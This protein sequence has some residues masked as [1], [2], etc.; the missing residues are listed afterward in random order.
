MRLLLLTVTLLLCAGAASAQQAGSD[1]TPEHRAPAA[2]AGELPDAK[3]LI[4]RYVQAIGGRAAVLAPTSSHARGRFEIPAAGV[5][6]E[7]EIFVAQPDRMLTV[8]TIP[9][10]GE[11]RSGFDGTV[12]WSLDPMM[13]PRRFTGAE[14]EATREQ[15]Q[16]LAA[17]RDPSLFTATETTEL[18][19]MGGE[20]CYRV[21]YL[22]RS[23]RET[24]DCF[25]SATGL[26]VASVA[27]QVSPMGSAEVVTLFGEHRT[28][29]G[30][31]MPTRITQI[32]AGQQQVLVIDEVDFDDVD[33]AVF[34]LPAE[35]R[36][37]VHD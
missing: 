19:E 15:A 10:L 6:A 32:A 27:T 35:I 8:I 14:L 25:S 16:M 5:R 9:G 2:P 4:D 13:G 36:A 29:G 28:F 37:L 24:F 17:V 31:R 1:R 18:V 21:R 33:P 7:L 20:P 23:G 26:L 12:G 3:R 30:I 11:V 22:W 34:E